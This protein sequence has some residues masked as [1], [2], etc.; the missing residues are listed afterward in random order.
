MYFI[1]KNKNMLFF[2]IITTLYEISNTLAFIAYDCSS[3]RLNITTFNTLNVDFC[4]IPK[5]YKVEKISNIKLLQ[6]TEVQSIQYQACY[7]I[8]DYLITRCSG[9]DDAQVV[10]NGYFSE[11]IQTGSAACGEAHKKLS[12]TFAYGNTAFNLKINQTLHFSD[13]IKGSLSRDGDCKGEAFKTDKHEWEDVIVQAKYKIFLSE[14]TAIA[15]NIDNVL[16]LPT[17]TRFKLS[18]SYGI[19]AHKGEVI[20][21]SNKKTDCT[22]DEYDTIYEGPASLV[23]STT[24]IN[25]ITIETQTF[26]VESNKIAFAL[27]KINT[28]FACNI[29]IFETEHPRLVI[30]TDISYIPLFHTK[31]LSTYNTDLMAYINTKFVYI[32]YSIKATITSM[33]LDII[34][35]QC[36]LERKQLLQK[37]SLASYSLSEFAYVMGEGP[38][39]TALKSGEVV[40]LLKC[41]P[42]DVQFA[43]HKVCFQ[44]LPVSYNNET[45][46]MAPKTHT[47]QKYGTEIDC[48]D[49]LPSAYLMEGEWVTMTPQYR[50]LAN[51]PQIL[52]PETSWT[53]TYKDPSNL[54]NAGLYSKDMINALQRH[55]LFPQEVDAAQS[56]IARQT[57]GYSVMDQGLK[58]KSLINEDVISR[59]IEEKLL[60]MW[61]WFVGFGNLVSGLLGIFCIWKL[62]MITL[63]T[64]LNIS[65]L[66][67]T[68]GCSFKILAGIF[69]GMT[70]YIM[71]K[72]H[73]RQ[74]KH[75]IYTQPEQSI[76]ENETLI[77][78]TVNGQDPQGLYPLLHHHTPSKT[79]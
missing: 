2:T 78:N 32:E 27:K 5:P 44:E 73:K 53:W 11:I 51:A 22:N 76:I 6:K 66:Y 77:L 30:V 36:T 54:M 59:L 14:G 62:I 67:Q 79:L 25:S 41:K 42:V 33:Y 55:L 21:N 13:T 45:L 9:F 31:P 75:N 37:L 56:N 39:F 7:I 23:T 46:F 17:G 57:M 50:P 61:G 69:S 64:S 68:F 43:H 18:D 65:I 38:G 19:D 24:S 12:Y 4:T 1:N 49:I 40:Y 60:N 63:N 15:N 47:L 8:A 58:M 72:A 52:K 16:I 74:Q 29:P 3:P 35:K 34:S 71:H 28:G 20:W 70:H 10:R 48:N 26:L